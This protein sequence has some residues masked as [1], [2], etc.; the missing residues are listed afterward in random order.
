MLSMGV[1]EL[2]RRAESFI[3]D[4]E[5]AA[6]RS[7]ISNLRFQIIDGFSAVGGGAAPHVS[8][9]TKLVAISHDS[10]SASRLEY[11]LRMAEIP[12][13][14]RIV[15]DRVVID[16]RTVDLEEESWI[17]KSLQLDG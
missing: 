1:D 4:L 6:S 7:E 10:F 9:P 16:L 8:L 14:T 11:S 15:D 13:I 5:N 2:Q 3:A 17:T 12:V